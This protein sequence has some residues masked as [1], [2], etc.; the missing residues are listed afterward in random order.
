MLSLLS[1]Q[2]SE[3]YKLET[4]LIRFFID[5]IIMFVADSKIICGSDFKLGKF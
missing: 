2:W 3:S 1:S 5:N 4:Y